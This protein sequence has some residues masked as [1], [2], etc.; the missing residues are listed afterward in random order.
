MTGL[1][2]QWNGNHNNEERSKHCR[3]NKLSRVTD[4]NYPR[5]RSTA[6]FAYA[7]VA[8]FYMKTC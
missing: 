3:G 1:A 5:L 4:Y 8:Q 2:F 6:F 7:L